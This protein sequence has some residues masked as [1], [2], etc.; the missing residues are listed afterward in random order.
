VVEPVEVVEVVPLEV[1]VVVPEVLELVEEDEVVVGGVVAGGG[2]ATVPL[3][4]VG[5]ALVTAVGAVAALDP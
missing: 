2:G 4:V 5:R 1:E 3:D